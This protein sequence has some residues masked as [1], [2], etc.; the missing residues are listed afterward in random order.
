MAGFGSSPSQTWSSSFAPHPMPRVWCTLIPNSRQ[1]ELLKRGI[2][3]AKH[4]SG[5][6]VCELWT[7]AGDGAPCSWLASGHSPI[8]PSECLAHPNLQPRADTPHSLLPIHNHSQAEEY[9]RELIGTNLGSACPTIKDG[10]ILHKHKSFSTPPPKVHW[11]MC[12]MNVRIILMLEK[13]LEVGKG[14]STYD[15]LKRYLCGER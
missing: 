8:E 15:L 5:W 2:G 14:C 13:L 12:A 4:S 11:H 10:M 3:A 9:S 1:A 6:C 7:E